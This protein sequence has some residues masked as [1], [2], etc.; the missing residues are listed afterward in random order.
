MS[1][2]LSIVLVNSCLE[3]YGI[4]LLICCSNFTRQRNQPITTHSLH[5]TPSK[6]LTV[7]YLICFFVAVGLMDEDLVAFLDTYYRKKS[8]RKK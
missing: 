8:E 7:A 2:S 5:A 3:K 4:M 1:N 6:I